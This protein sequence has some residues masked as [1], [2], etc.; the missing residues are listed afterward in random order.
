MKRSVALHSGLVHSLFS[1]IAWMIHLRISCAIA[2]ARAFQQLFPS[3][4]P[5]RHSFTPN[6]LR[7][8]LMSDCIRPCNPP[9]WSP[10][11]RKHS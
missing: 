7:V 6:Q 8:L 10:F 5:R 9:R 3:L 2:W 4:S 11:L 1:L